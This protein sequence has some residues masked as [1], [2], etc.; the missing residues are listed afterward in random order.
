MPLA[1]F[2]PKLASIIKIQ[3]L[4]PKSTQGTQQGRLIVRMRKTNS[5]FSNHQ[6][7]HNLKATGSSDLKLSQKLL[8]TGAHHPAKFQTPYLPAV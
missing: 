8:T 6:N 5:N 1:C 3:I 2:P 7:S 4:A